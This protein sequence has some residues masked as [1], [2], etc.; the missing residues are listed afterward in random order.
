MQLKD[1]MYYHLNVLRAGL[2]GF[3]DFVG[4]LLVGFGCGG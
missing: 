4:W 1:P 3:L 2:C